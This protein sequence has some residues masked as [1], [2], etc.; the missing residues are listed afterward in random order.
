MSPTLTTAIDTAARYQLA[1]PEQAP[2]LEVNGY[3]AGAAVIGLILLAL[4]ISAWRRKSGGMTEGEKKYA[5]MAFIAALC[6][7]GTGGVV[8]SI[9]DT[10][11][12]TVDQTGTTIT[13]T[14]VTR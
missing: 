5:S 1:V 4:L 11:K 7:Y 8:G 6:L 3:G 2:S 12:R 14:A 13:Q 10:T 9:L